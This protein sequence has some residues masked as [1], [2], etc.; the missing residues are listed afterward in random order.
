MASGK[1]RRGYTDRTNCV[2]MDWELR[3]TQKISPDYGRIWKLES[4]AFTL[5]SWC[6][7]L[8]KTRTQWGTPSFQQAQGALI[9]ASSPLSGAHGQERWAPEA[10][11]IKG[12]EGPKELRKETL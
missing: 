12:F 8:G 2:M 11:K 4:K 10:A 3:W 5:E 6:L 1:G 7:V 9:V